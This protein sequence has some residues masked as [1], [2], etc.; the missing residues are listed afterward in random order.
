MEVVCGR[1]AVREALG[2]P[3]RVKRV[4]LAEGAR[5]EGLVAEIARLARSQGI[6][7]EVRRRQELDRLAGPVAHQG[8]VAETR[9]YEYASLAE[10]LD[11]A[12][13]PGNVALLLVLD[14][15][16]DPQNL[17]SLLRTAEAVGAHG[18]VIPRQR[19]AG[20][21]PAVERASAGAVE[22][23]RIAQVANLTQALEAMKARGIWAAGLEKQAQSKPYDQ[24]DWR[25]PVALVVGSEGRG[26][27]RLVREHCDF[28]VDIPM[29][30]RVG[31]LNA[32]VAGSIV[33]Y[34][35]LRQRE[36]ERILYQAPS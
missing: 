32:A 9:P 4:Y 17:G 31:S 3:D 28:L 16:Q 11:G 30:G 33:L 15:L 12:T 22:H 23:L 7:V 24:V 25:L 18:V 19:A 36:G 34:E 6:A 2:R 27:S 14:C 10:V 20:V 5:P 8:V 21:T 1:N 29:R 26:M 35:I 13:A